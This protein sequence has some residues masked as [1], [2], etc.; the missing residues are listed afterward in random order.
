MD[1]VPMVVATSS[2]GDTQS[3]KDTRGYMYD[4][5]DNHT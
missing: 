3:S 2:T 4:S 1:D 5:S